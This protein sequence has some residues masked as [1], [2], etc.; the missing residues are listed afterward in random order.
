MNRPIGTILK[1][2]LEAEE[3]LI[4]CCARIKP[5]R[6][7]I[8]KMHELVDGEVDWER[9]LQLASS[10]RVLPLVYQSLKQCDLSIPLFVIERLE[11]SSSKIAKWNIYLTGELFRILDLL[12]AHN[13]AAIPYKGPALADAV[14]GD[15]CLR[16]FSDLD[17]LV[18]EQDVLKVKQLL[19]TE[20]FKPEYRFNRFQ[21]T[22]YLNVGCEY[23]F[24]DESRN[25]HV[26]IHWR[27]LPK[28]FA[29]ARRADRLWEGVKVRSLA[30]RTIREFR[31]E[32]LLS[33]LCMHGFKHCWERLSLIC[34]IA[35]LIRRNEGMDWDEVVVRATKSGSLR[36]LSLGLF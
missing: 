18:R 13:I 3:E 21:E 17:I 26:E 1:T 32:D 8:S 9:F 25:L 7:T 14:Y 31:P 2:E 11:Q 29:Q 36:L 6:Q 5:D 4:L 28:L 12:D 22:A 20:G 35:E 34:D 30:G 27:I 16:Q 19:V 33:H 23:N 15:L 24:N 10:N